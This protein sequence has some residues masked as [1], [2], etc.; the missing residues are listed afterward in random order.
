[1]RSALRLLRVNTA[2][3]KKVV[4]DALAASYNSGGARFA[5]RSS[6]D[7]S[8]LGE[9]ED[10]SVQIDVGTIRRDN[11]R[12]PTDRIDLNSGSSGATGL[13]TPLNQSRFSPP[14]LISSIRSSCRIAAH[15]DVARILES[16]TR[17][18]LTD[19][20]RNESVSSFADCAA[21]EGFTNARASKQ[22][23]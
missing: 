15:E 3:P 16:R 22:C 2:D 19:G 21:T 9:A 18:S 10:G 1:M 12:L 5:V 17:G 8:S 6:D 7:M 13:R 11:H 20:R 4:I 14:P 23:H